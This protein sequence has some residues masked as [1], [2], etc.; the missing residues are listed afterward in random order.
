M[1]FVFRF[2]SEV[3]N[4][5]KY[6]PRI[7]WIKGL[8]MFPILSYAGLLGWMRKGLRNGNWRRLKTTEK[9]LFKAALWYA[10]FKGRILN[11]KVASQLLSIVEK[12]KD[13]LGNRIVQ[14]GVAAAKEMLTRGEESAVFTWCP[15]LRVWLTEPRYVFWLG[16]TRL[17][18]KYYVQG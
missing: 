9:A 1:V 8:G 11:W 15:Q 4:L 10:R 2:S 17:S 3:V 6:V 7:Y 13:T 5:F 12:I 18:T 16:L 14:A